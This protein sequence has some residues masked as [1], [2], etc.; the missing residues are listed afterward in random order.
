M[1][2]VDHSDY[3]V[4]QLVWEGETHRFAVPTRYSCGYAAARAFD[5]IRQRERTPRDRFTLDDRRP[6]DRVAVWYNDG[7]TA[8]IIR[9]STEEG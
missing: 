6:T 3:C 5:S 8:T 2:R 9:M 1:I 7:A 4:M